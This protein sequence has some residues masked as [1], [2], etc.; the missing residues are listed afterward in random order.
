[1][2]ILGNEHRIATKG[3]PSPIQVGKR[4]VVERTHSWVNA[5]GKLRRR[6]DKRRTLVEVQLFLAATITVLR[7]LIDTSHT[8]YRWDT[9]P[10][11]RRLP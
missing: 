10:I 7:R 11:T 8:H 5:Y 1:M 6:T 3:K 4:W 2:H 9:R